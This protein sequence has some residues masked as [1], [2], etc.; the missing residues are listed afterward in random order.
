MVLVAITASIYPYL[1]QL[2]FK[3]DTLNNGK[4]MSLGLWNYSR[5]PNYFGEITLWTGVAVMS[6]SSLSGIEYLT[7]ISPIFTYLLLVY[8]S[9]IRILEHN[10]NKKWALDKNY[11]DYKEKTSVLIPFLTYK[12]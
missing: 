10:G 5:H 1:I 9:G 11:Q 4:V 3:K 7:L 2:V 8:V 6:F 12:R